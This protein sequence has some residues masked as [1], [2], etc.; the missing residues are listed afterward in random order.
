VWRFGR[1][2]PRMINVSSAVI[3]VYHRFGVFANDCLSCCFLPVCFPSSE[4]LF[5]LFPRWFHCGLIFLY[6][7][8]VIYITM[9]MPIDSKSDSLISY[10]FAP[11]VGKEY[12]MTPVNRIH[13]NAIGY[14][15][16][17]SHISGNVQLRSSTRFPLYLSW[18]ILQRILDYFWSFHNS[19]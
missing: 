18:K 2:A 14:L 15:H 16:P 5:A 4:N 19:C 3:N 8:L 13:L 1:V 9:I 6:P 11:H 17:G 7:F 12:L 10:I